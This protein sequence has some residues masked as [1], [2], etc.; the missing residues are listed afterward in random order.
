[1]IKGIIV[2]LATMAV[3]AVVYHFWPG[4]AR[5]AFF[6]PPTVGDKRIPVIGGAG[7]TGMMLVGG[8]VCLGF[9]KAIKG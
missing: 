4:V 5:E 6:I 7:V 2:V 9:W 3:C 1:M 8:L